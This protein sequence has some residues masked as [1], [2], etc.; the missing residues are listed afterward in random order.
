MAG[1]KFITLLAQRSLFVCH[2]MWCLLLDCA[3]LLQLQQCYFLCLGAVAAYLLLV[4][5]L[6]SSTHVVLSTCGFYTY[7]TK[8]SV[9]VLG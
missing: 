2:Q 8:H 4:L 5:Q 1:V 7:K 3:V 6:S 9:A